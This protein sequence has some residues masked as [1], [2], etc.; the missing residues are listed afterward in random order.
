[1]VVTV[2]NLFSEYYRHK[3]S[4]GVLLFHDNYLLLNVVSNKYLFS[5]LGNFSEYHL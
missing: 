3:Y 2:T 1:M 4:I 5:E